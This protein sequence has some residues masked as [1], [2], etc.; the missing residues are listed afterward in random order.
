MISPSTAPAVRL[1]E[2]VCGYD[3]KPVVSATSLEVGRGEI[4]VIAG[5]S[6]CGK[7]TVMRT[8]AGLLLPVDGTVEVLGVDLWTADLPERRP[9]LRRMGM[10]FQGGALLG[11]MTV[12]EN[13]MLPVEEYF[14]RLPDAV[15]ARL[16]DAKLA[17]VGLGGTGELDPAALSGG[18]R[19]R[20][21]LA[22]AL[23]LDPD[24]LL[25]DEPTSGLDPVVAAG[26]DELVLE[27]RARLDMAMVVISHDL[28]SI[29]RIADRVLLLHDGKPV[30]L[31]TVAEL[32]QATLPEIHAFFHREAPA[33]GLGG[34]TLGTRLRLGLADGG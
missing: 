27:L 11:S 18:M 26:I 2:L 9:V 29:R 22:R 15:A 20:V 32:E 24:L 7:S 3:G 14:G 28:D 30:A 1:C 12:A 21:A 23:M 34:H 25:C 13:L 19:K 6:G 5:R 17:Q 31:G 8:V 33:E 4:L 16:V 10:M